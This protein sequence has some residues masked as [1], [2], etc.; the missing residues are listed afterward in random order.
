MIQNSEQSLKR[1]ARH[2]SDSHIEE[3]KEEES[4]PIE[5]EE[6][7]QQN[8]EHIYQLKVDN[9]DPNHASEDDWS[10]CSERIHQ[11]DTKIPELPTPNPNPLDKDRSVFEI[12]SSKI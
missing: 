5:K 10:I 2:Q 12:L 8:I 6:S 4:P 9:F 7:P 3:V 1:I 11:E